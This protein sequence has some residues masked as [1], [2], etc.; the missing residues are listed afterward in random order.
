[1]LL[2][3]IQ[4]EEARI[5]RESTQSTNANPHRKKQEW[6]WVNLKFGIG[7]DMMREKEYSEPTL[8]R[9]NELSGRNES[10]GSRLYSSKAH[11]HVSAF[12]SI[13]PSLSLFFLGLT[14]L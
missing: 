7:Q 4:Q 2:C 5:Y 9:E 10:G 8:E 3:Q 6:S 14:M 12:S 11:A 1:M 13:L